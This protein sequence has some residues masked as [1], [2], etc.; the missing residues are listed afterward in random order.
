MWPY[1]RRLAS[2]VR[3]LQIRV[4]NLADGDLGIRERHFESIIHRTLRQVVR[5]QDLPRTLVQVTLQITTGMDQDSASGRS[6]P[7]ESVRF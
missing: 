5:V 7:A 4:V 1:G 2:A 6:N 3:R